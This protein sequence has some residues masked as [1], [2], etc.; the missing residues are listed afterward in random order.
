MKKGV[1]AGLLIGLL[2]GMSSL[3]VSA[4]AIDKIAQ[5]QETMLEGEH[6]TEDEN[7]PDVEQILESGEGAIEIFD[8]N[9]VEYKGK[10][11]LPI[12]TI[13]V[14][15]VFVLAVTLITYALKKREYEEE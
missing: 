2:L 3:F 12:M 9:S 10:S 13:A 6:M 5:I 15:V 7:L 14:I 4:M 11:V 8:I 1:L